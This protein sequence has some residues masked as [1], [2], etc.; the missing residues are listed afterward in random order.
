MKSVVVG[1]EGELLEPVLR[2]LLPETVRKRSTNGDVV[3]LAAWEVAA[4]ELPVV[5]E[6]GKSATLAAIMLSPLALSVRGR[7][8]HWHDGS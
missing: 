1:T 5:C 6:P 2:N 3:D 7:K 8:G 4:D